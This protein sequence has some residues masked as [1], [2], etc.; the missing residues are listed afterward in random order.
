MRFQLAIFCWNETVFEDPKLIYLE[1]EMARLLQI[2][3]HYGVKRTILNP[4]IREGV[5]R[6]DRKRI[7][8]NFENMFFGVTDE[9]QMI[10]DALIHFTVSGPRHAF[11]VNNTPDGIRHAHNVGLTTIALARTGA[12]ER[13]MRKAKPDEIVRSPMEI[14]KIFLAEK[15]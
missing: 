2:L 13:A 1:R 3:G 12:A 14:L 5:D 7:G 6:F 11:Y 8:Q 10:V 4:A 15:M 9:K